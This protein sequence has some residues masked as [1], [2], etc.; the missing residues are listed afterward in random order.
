M[1]KYKYRLVEQEEEE[2][3]LKKLSSKNELHL[4]G[5]GEYTADKLK[6][7]INDP[8]NLTGHRFNIEN[9]DLKKIKEQVFGDRPNI[10]STKDKNIEI[11]KAY[12]KSFYK[13]IEN[14]IGREFDKRN[15]VK[16]PEF[17]FPQINAY[18]IK[19]VEDYFKSISDKQTKK[20]SLSAVKIDDSTLKFP[21]SDEE[22][23]KNILKNAK[24]VSGKDYTLEKIKSLDENSYNIIKKEIKNLFENKNLSTAEK[25]IKQ[26]EKEGHI[27]GDYSQ[28]VLD[29][30][31]KI[32]KKW[33]ELSSEEQKVMR[34]TYYQS[35]LKK[36]KK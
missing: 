11:Y 14:T 7:T 18:N 35:F 26:A 8:K 19:A 30:A 13:E 3:G 24:L 6:Q 25:L 27:K 16:T 22:N 33:D 5:L 20:S 21:V 2:N 15:L 31:K 10:R 9:A 12:G 17:V 29:A 4:K 32:A 34:D 28:S 23:L 36:I 1:N